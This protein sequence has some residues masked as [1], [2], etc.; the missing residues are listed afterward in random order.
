MDSEISEMIEKLKL[1]K[2]MLA[3]KVLE[4]S[5]N[6]TKIEQRF[7]DKF[8]KYEERIDLL[9]AKVANY[10]D[11]N[12]VKVEDLKKNE[13]K[14]AED[15][16][17]ME[18]EREVIA[19][20]IKLADKNLTEMKDS[21]DKITFKSVEKNEPKDD[22]KVV[23]DDDR[24]QCRYDNKGYCCQSESCNFFHPKSICNLYLQTG[25][26]WRQNCR[27]RHPRVCRYDSRCFRG[28][29][30]RYLHLT[31]LCDHCNE[32]SQKIYYC[33]FC[34]KNFCDHCTVEKAHI[35]NIYDVNSDHN[36]TCTQI[37][38]LAQNPN[39]ERMDQD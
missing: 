30:C 32:F 38:K 20:K 21:I 27:Q 24:K 25:T 15:V 35:E 6:L 31:N 37:H 34:T 2:R 39:C 9:E 12:N 10:V 33:E 16:S 22:E 29:S 5:K 23:D 28:K 11:T 13:D 36:P 3:R 26:C 8:T 4:L 7:E 1:E 19:E 17:I 18:A 14:L